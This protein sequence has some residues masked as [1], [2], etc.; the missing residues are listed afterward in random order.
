MTKLGDEYQEIVALV[1]QA[2]DPDAQVKA[3]Q[4][5]EG[6]D[7]QRDMDVEVR[8]TI[9]GERH[10]ILVECKDWKRKAGI[11]VVDA[12][13]SKRR[14]LGADSAVI[15]SNSGFTEPSLRKGKRVGIRLFSALRAG[16]PRIRFILHREIV[17]K[18]RSVTKYSILFFGDV[19]EMVKL[20][21]DWT[22]HDIEYAG[23]PM[24]N[25]FRD[26]SLV[27]LKQEKMAKSITATYVFD[28]PILIDVQGN[29]ISVK[30]MQL[31]MECIE[32]HVSQIVEE[33]VTLGHYDFLNDTV[34][35]PNKQALIVGQF[36]NTKWREIDTT[37]FKI[38]RKEQQPNS[39]QFE[40]T[41]FKPVV[42]VD[43]AGTPQLSALIKERS[44]ES[45]QNSR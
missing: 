4:W 12:L 25:F 26:E 24:V 42:G 15:Y 45:D 33:N 23:K 21:L 36:D 43:E 11:G 14:D 31:I 39:I 41:L 16:D 28:L 6:P 32:T 29:S 8:G 44:I 18:V 38:E 5:I 1:Q 13:E 7:G 2:L 40:F 10:F 27:I 37:K 9:N 22:P 30:V 35:I 34:T 17:A 20:P 3:G 19:D